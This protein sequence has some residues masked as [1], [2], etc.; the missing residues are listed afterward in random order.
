MSMSKEE[1]DRVLSSITPRQFEAIREVMSVELGL[2]DQAARGE[3]CVNRDWAAGFAQSCAETVEFFD[4]AAQ[5]G[6]QGQADR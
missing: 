3:R 1:R 6:W 2:A 4:V 5:A